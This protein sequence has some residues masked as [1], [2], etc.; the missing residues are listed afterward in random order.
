M[1]EKRAPGQFLRLVPRQWR[2]PPPFFLLLLYVSP[3][4]LARIPPHLLEAMG[5]RLMATLGK[6]RHAPLGTRFSDILRV[7]LFCYLAC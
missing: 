2:P 6:V 3:S 4:R 1:V 5:S 7:C